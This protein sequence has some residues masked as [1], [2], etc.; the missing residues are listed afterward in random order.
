MFVPLSEQLQQYHSLE[1]FVVGELLLGGSVGSLENTLSRLFFVFSP[2]MRGLTSA[3]GLLM[4][5]PFCLSI[6]HPMINV[7]LHCCCELQQ[8]KHHP[9]K[10]DDATLYKNYS[11][12]K[13]SFG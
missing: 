9:G 5:D 13:R 10:K 8:L 6:L 11:F 2:V 3:G 1:S 7:C 12:F 4:S